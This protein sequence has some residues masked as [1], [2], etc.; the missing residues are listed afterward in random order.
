M[1]W[2]ELVSK[3][4]PG[5]DI[6]LMS[7]ERPDGDAWGSV[8][9]FALV[10]E[11]LGF[12]PRYMHVGIQ[13][14]RRH[15][16]LPGQHL[17]EL[18]ATKDITLPDEAAVFVLDCGDL[19]RCEFSLEPEMV[20]LNVD[21]H[22]S[23]PRYGQIDWVDPRA[24]ATAQIIG[25]ILIDNHIPISQG[26]ATCFY[27]ALASD[28]GGFR[29]SNTSGETMRVASVMHDSGADLPIIRRRLWEDRPLQE[30][31]L[32]QEMMRSMSLVAE[33]KGV[34]CE[35][36]YGVIAGSEI[37]DAETDNALEIIRSVGGI[38][39]VVLLKEIE[40]DVVKVSVRSKDYLDSAAFMG[41][42][43]GGGHLKA[44]GATLNEPY[45]K[46]RDIVCDLLTR[47]LLADGGMG[48]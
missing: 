3:L 22:I 24:G 27:T 32:L 42:M 6:R 9:G 13:P 35:L 20:L 8:L 46:V 29:F 12:K 33:G 40:P 41:L 31:L 1:E 36:P 44:A 14:S 16:W 5:H 10:L 45:D 39:A 43:G 2:Q 37:Y 19:S 47:A 18:H 38:E 4:K 21:H 34:L 26:A 28:T 11:S 48:A 17:I 23:N 7:H 30:L 25:R 15:G